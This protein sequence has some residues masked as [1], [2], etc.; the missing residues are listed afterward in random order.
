MGGSRLTQ[1]ARG[2]IWVLFLCHGPG[3]ERTGAE[4]IDI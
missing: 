2:E 1:K 4:R 3:V